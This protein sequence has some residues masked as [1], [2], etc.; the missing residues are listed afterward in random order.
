MTSYLNQISEVRVTE[1][2]LPRVLHDSKNYS[3]N[4]LLLEYSLNST[5]GFNFYK[6]NYLFVTIHANLDFAISTSNFIAAFFV[7][8]VAYWYTFAEIKVMGAKLNGITSSF[9]YFCY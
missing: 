4:F 6:L 1:L 5:S 8:R 7:L 2:G 3:S 9:N